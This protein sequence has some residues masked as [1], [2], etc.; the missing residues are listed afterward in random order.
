[1][2]KKTV[3]LPPDPATVAFALAGRTPP[4]RH[5]TKDDRAALEAL[6]DKTSLH[7]VVMA[8]AA[9]GHDKAIHIR[10]HWQDTS[11]ASLWDRQADLLAKRAEVCRIDG[12]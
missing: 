3:L 6:I 11:L 8:I 7:Q 10:E 1:M 5:V 4:A 9:I 12:L 2:S